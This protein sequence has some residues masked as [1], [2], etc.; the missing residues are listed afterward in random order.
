M[1]ITPCGNRGRPRTSKPA[2]LA[3]PAS[4]RYMEPARRGGRVAEGARLESVFT[5]NRNAGSNPA[6]SA[7]EAHAFHL[8]RAGFSVRL[9]LKICDGVRQSPA[10]VGLFGPRE[11]EVL[12]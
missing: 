12:C 10:K 4:R 1:P 7:S 9:S 6:P 8:L 5:G 11:W 3:N 2:R